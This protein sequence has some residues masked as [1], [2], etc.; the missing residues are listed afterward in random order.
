MIPPPPPPSSRLHKELCD[1]LVTTSPSEIREYM[2]IKVILF[3]ICRIG[4][5]Q[6]DIIQLSYSLW[7]L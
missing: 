6:V 7:T 2:E 3:S 1:L 4:S 5:T